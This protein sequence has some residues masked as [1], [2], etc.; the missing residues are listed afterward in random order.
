MPYSRNF[1]FSLCFFLA[2]SCVQVIKHPLV[3]LQRESK[4]FIIVRMDTKAKI[5]LSY[6]D[7]NMRTKAVVF[8]NLTNIDTIIIKSINIKSPTIFSFAEFTGKSLLK[9]N[10]IGLPN[11]SIFFNLK[12][13]SLFLSD[14]SKGQSALDVVFGKVDVLQENKVYGSHII[15]H[16]IDSV[17][18]S[19]NFYQNKISNYAEKY[20]WSASIKQVLFDVNSI[21]KLN[22]I[23][24]I[25][26]MS[27]SKNDILQ[28]K[29]SNFYIEFIQRKNLLEKLNYEMQKSLLYNTTSYAAKVKTAEYQNDIFSNLEFIDSSLFKK[30]YTDGFI[31]D[32]LQN[33]EII[34]TS[35]EKEK[36]IKSLDNII[37]NRA[38]F[39][40]NS[41][42]NSAKLDSSILLELIENFY[43]EKIGLSEIFK[44]NK[45]FIVIDFW[46]SWCM[47]CISEFPSLEKWK[48]KY[49]DNVDFISISIDADR[50]QWVKG[51]KKFNL[52]NNSYR[53]VLGKKSPFSGL[54]SLQAIPRFVVLNNKSELI[55]KNFYRPSDKRF[56]LNLSE[57]L[58]KHN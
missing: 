19:F 4:V 32:I 1:I 56:D 24:K 31:Y 22:D 25:D 27:I 5:A 34:Q 16:L 48:K 55:E 52:V 2:N 36:I 13:T 18:K 8:N 35:F 26:F 43:G 11:D 33:S 40:T 3:P 15:D 38:S 21:K 20:N 29:I 58:S 10:Y 14:T 57:Y 41:S 45:K 44:T 49:S 54:L 47:P 53:I 46:A 6:L 28:S 17:Q 39:Y 37:L 42:R 51:C 23:F 50:Q 12:N 7:T 30:D 9:S